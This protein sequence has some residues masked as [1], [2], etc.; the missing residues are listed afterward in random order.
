[1]RKN[2]NDEI[3]DTDLTSA[4]TIYLIALNLRD[5]QT[6]VELSKFLDYDLANTSRVIKTLMQKGYVY[7]DRKTPHSRGYRIFLTVT[8]RNLSERVMEFER[9]KYE[10]YFKNVDV[11]D[12]LHLRDTL[13]SIL[14]NMDPDLDK[15]MSSP[16]DNPYYTLLQ[17][18]PSPDDSDEFFVTGR[19]PYKEK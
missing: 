18:N 1:M 15:Y 7:D 9:S 14:R 17:T 12:L 2:V 11:E 8:G 5:G 4:H 6:M 13:I 16:F 10:E 19:L 3:A